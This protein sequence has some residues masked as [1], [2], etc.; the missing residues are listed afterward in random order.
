MGRACMA[1]RWH[2]NIE[3]NCKAEQLHALNFC[4]QTAT[5]TDC[6]LCDRADL[7]Q[8]STF[9]MPCDWEQLAETAN[10]LELC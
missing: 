9:S 3:K 6:E 2:E 4:V 7:L 8:H 5:N 10:F 1:M